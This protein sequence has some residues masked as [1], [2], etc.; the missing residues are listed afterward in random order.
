MYLL[1][2]KILVLCWVGNNVTQI[3]GLLELNLMLHWLSGI[4]TLHD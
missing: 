1:G 2:S 4:E 3:Q